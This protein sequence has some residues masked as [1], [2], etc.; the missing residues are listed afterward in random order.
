MRQVLFHIPIYLFDPEGIPVYG[1]GGMLFVAFI[2]TTLL[3]AVLARRERIRPDHIQDMA[4]WIFVGGIVGARI[5]YMIQYGEPIGKFFKIWDG[6]LVFYGSAIG[7]SVG[8]FVA[9]ALILRKHGIPTWRVADLVAPCA[10]LG[11][12]LGRVGCFLNGCC[13]GNV[14]C[15]HCPGV[16]FPL[17]AAPRED[18]TGRGYQTAAGFTLDPIGFTID[19]TGAALKQV[20]VGRVEPNS[21][22]ARAGLQNGDEILEARPGFHERDVTK[23]ADLK[24]LL[25]LGGDWPRG[26][27]QLQLTVRRAGRV[28]QLEPFEVNQARVVRVEPNSPADQAGLKEGDRIIRASA[29]S[30][31]QDIGSYRALDNFLGLGRGWPRGATEL[32]LTV[33]RADG[34][35]ELEAFQPWT[36]PLHPTQLYESISMLLLF[37]LLLAFYPFRRR[38]GEVMVL[39]MIGYAVHRFFNEMLR[40]DTDPI[41]LLGINTH[42]TLSQNISILV[43]LSALLL[44]LWLRLQPAERGFAALPSSVPAP[45]EREATSVVAG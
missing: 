14:A 34:V 37:F 44:V 32:Q 18:M 4:I 19:P 25:T 42:M 16:S 43:L 20:R 26:E 29:G 9:Y 24:N 45:R 10:A 13:Y 27:T 30:H 15:E 5:T 2:L 8:Y 41:T 28:H 12:C 11:L 36:I 40:D 17:S 1:Y 33:R 22:A 7:G 3:A 6:G 35:H 39:F 21:P 23:Y 31:E 38:P